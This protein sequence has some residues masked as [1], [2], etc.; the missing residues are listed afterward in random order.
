MSRPATFEYRDVSYSERL[1]NR[2]LEN[3][4]SVLFNRLVM[5][6][7]FLSSQLDIQ[8]SG[9]DKSFLSLVRFCPNLIRSLFQC[10]IKEQ[11]RSLVDRN[12]REVVQI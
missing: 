6:L 4:T 10:R 3:W 8:G 2:T 12:D 1:E 9:I 5:R 7:E 11:R